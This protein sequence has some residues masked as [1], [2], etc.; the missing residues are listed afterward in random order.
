MTAFRQEAYKHLVCPLCHAGVEVNGDVI[1][2]TNQSCGKEY[3]L[4]NGIPIM[5]TGGALPEDEASGFYPKILGGTME[6]NPSEVFS[7]YDSWIR[8]HYLKKYLGGESS[9]GLILDVCCSKAPFYPYLQQWGFDGRV[10]GADLLLHQ[11][12]IASER[13]VN[14]VQANALHLPFEDGHFALTIFTDALVHLMKRHDQE[15]VLNEIARVLKPGGA[16]FLTATNLGYV[17]MEFVAE[18]P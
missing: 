1:K 5:L 7:S 11:L 3:G 16:L 13:G 9:D 18:R 2:C 6:D 10:F 8:T 4:K 15:G 12:E 17:A 14:A